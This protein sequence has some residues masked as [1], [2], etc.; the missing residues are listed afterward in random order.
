MPDGCEEG[1]Q[2]IVTGLP[3]G[4]A[5][6]LRVSLRRVGVKVEGAVKTLYGMRV[7]AHLHKR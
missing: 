7:V 5:G 1:V 3:L 2:A 4:H 6:S